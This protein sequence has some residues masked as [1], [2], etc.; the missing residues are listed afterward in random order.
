M[1]IYLSIL[2]ET[3]YAASTVNEVRDRNDSLPGTKQNKVG[4]VRGAFA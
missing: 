3:S 4:N 2:L 1:Q